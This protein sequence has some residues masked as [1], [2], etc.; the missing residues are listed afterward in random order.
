VSFNGVC[1]V[2][3]Y[4]FIDIWLFKLNFWVFAANLVKDT[5]YFYKSGSARKDIWLSYFYY[6]WEIT[7][8]SVTNL[9]NLLKVSIRKLLIKAFFT[10]E[11]LCDV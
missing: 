10:F 1:Y 3:H 2:G 11:M 8:H 4:L 6:L 5:A 7:D 9:K